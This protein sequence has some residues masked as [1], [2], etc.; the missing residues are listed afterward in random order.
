[1]TNKLPTVHFDPPRAG[2]LRIII[3]Y[4]QVTVPIYASS[5]FDPFPTFSR[6]LSQVARGELPVTWHINEEDSAMTLTIQS[7]PTHDARLIL[8][9]DHPRSDDDEEQTAEWRTFLDIAVEPTALARSFSA[10]FRAYL[11]AGFNPEEWGTD[12]R[13]LELNSAA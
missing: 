1:M 12:L 13:Q 2:W 5:A 6:W 11:Q 10:A 8:A 7:A 9:G 3:A 4:D